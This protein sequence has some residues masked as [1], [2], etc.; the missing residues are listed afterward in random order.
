MPSRVVLHGVEGIGKSSFGASAPAPIF[1]MARGETGLETLIDSGR[2]PDIPHFPEI[3][4]WSDLLGVID[5]LTNDDHPYKTLVI[6]TLNGCERLCHEHVCK[7]DFKDDWGQAGF[8]GYMRGF[9]VSVTDW[10]ELLCKLDTIRETRRMAILAL[11]HTKIGTFKNP[12]GEDFDRFQPAI[13]PK[14]WELTSRWA[15]M[16]LFAN[17]ETVT[18][19]QKGR[20]KGFG[21]TERI[22]YTQRTAAFDAKN[23]C[24]LPEELSMGEAGVEAWNNFASA[25]KSAKETA[26]ASQQKV[27][28]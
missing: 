2:L 28:V 12:M 11:C 8:T 10:R 24:G 18:K 1:A 3:Q 5:T 16:V 26:I 23:R 14:T 20:V 4:T 9:E 15:D 6:D 22:I 21:G 13:H 17:F 19:E 27:G 25:L 7:R